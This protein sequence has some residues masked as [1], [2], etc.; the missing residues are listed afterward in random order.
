[1]PIK[2]TLTRAERNRRAQ[3]GVPLSNPPP[4]IRRHDQRSPMIDLDEQDRLAELE[5]AASA[6]PAPKPVKAKKAATR[7]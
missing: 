7:G 2:Q 4:L 3:N 5:L 1:M 6:P